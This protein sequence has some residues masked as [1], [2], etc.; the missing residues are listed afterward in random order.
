MVTLCPVCECEC[1]RAEQRTHAYER[2]I[3]V[4]AIDSR[5]QEWINAKTLA[6]FVFNKGNAKAIFD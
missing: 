2:Q 3:D 4:C 1:G 5:S 6:V